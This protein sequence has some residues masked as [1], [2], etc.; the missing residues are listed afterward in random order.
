MEVF[1]I[2]FRQENHSP[3]MS[4]DFYSTLDVAEK[5]LEKKG[6][7]EKNCC[8]E[9]IIPITKNGNKAYDKWAVIF[10]KD[11]ITE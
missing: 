6:Y 1:G 10:S 7:T 2:I 8:N 3:C 4:K 9:Y 11:V 5:N